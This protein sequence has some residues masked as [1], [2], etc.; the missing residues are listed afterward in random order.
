MIVG[1]KIAVFIRG[2]YEFV[3]IL[4]R[5]LTR[6]GVTD[7]FHFQKLVF[8]NIFNVALI[9]ANQSLVVRIFRKQVE[10]YFALELIELTARLS[11]I[12]LVCREHKE[13]LVA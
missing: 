12:R 7:L 5:I 10:V 6:R 13:I 2:F 3:Y 1:D 4:H 11:D 9:V 8:G